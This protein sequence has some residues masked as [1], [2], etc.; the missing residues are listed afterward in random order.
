MRDFFAIGSENIGF[1][2][3]GASSFMNQ[4]SFTMEIVTDSWRKVMDVHL[5]C[6]SGVTF[7]QQFIG[8]CA[9]RCVE[10]R[11]SKT[12]MDYAKG[13]IEH[14]CNRNI[15]FASFMIESPIHMQK[16]VDIRT[17]FSA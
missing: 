1:K 12:A 9:H 15:N 3:D 17:V 16:A 2:D 13:I 8:K 7:W 6:D 14:I 5:R 11:G 10:Y 4:R